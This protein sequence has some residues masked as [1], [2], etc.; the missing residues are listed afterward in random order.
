MIKDLVKI[1]NQNS[2][3]KALNVRNKVKEKNIKENKKRYW[4]LSAS[5][6]LHYDFKREKIDEDN[7]IKPFSTTIQI[8]WIYF[9]SLIVFTL[10]KILFQVDPTLLVK[11]FLTIIG[12]APLLFKVSILVD[13]LI[14]VSQLLNKSKRREDLNKRYGFKKI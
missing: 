12:T 6:R 1:A 9:Y 13:F 4:K 2:L 11:A 7:S 5:E 8:I 3:L 14:F 10:F